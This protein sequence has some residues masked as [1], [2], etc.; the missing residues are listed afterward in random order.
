MNSGIFK[1]EPFVKDSEQDPRWMI[2]NPDGQWIASTV[3]G[4]DE[5][6]AKLIANACNEYKK[7][8][9]VRT[10]C[11]ILIH[12]QGNVLLG[13]RGKDCGVAPD[14]YAFPGGKMDYG[15][16]PKQAIVREV[17]E[18]T[19]L[20]ILEK[21]VSFFRYCNEFFPEKNKHYISLVFIIELGEGEPIRKEPDKCK[22]WEWIY[23]GNLPKN[24]FEPTRE[25]I[26]MAAEIILGIA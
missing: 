18:E 5:E 23:P 2:E 13:E 19:G 25:S 21:D 14:L 22:G 6:N 15:E 26:M 11:T 7:P 4:H 16:T 20:V 17:F 10:S 3:G 12:R 1:A 9:P 8:E 24:M